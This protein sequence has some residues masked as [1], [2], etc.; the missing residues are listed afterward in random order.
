MLSIYSVPHATIIRVNYTII[1]EISDTWNGFWIFS[2]FE[3]DVI[4]DDVAG[5]SD[6]I[7]DFVFDWWIGERPREAS[8]ANRGWL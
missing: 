7:L 8:P 5:S 1:E 6:W 3:N 4:G 2:K